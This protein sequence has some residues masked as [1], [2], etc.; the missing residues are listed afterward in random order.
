[1]STIA[2]MEHVE[3]SL[4]FSGDEQ[5][6]ML[7]YDNILA[8]Y[9]SSQILPT[10][11]KPN[12]P[13][14]HFA[15]IYINQNGEV[16]LEVSPSIAS[17]GKAIFT[18]DI[19]ERF[20]KTAAMGSRVAPHS[21]PQPI[22]QAK[23]TD[24]SLGFQPGTNWGQ[25]SLPG[26][27]ELIPCDWQF[28]QN[29]RQKRNTKRR[30][31]RADRR[32]SSSGLNEGSVSPSPAFRRTALKVSDEDRMKKYYEK[33]FDAFQQLNCRVIAKAYIKLVEPRKQ[34][35]HPYN[36]RKTAA[37][38]SSEQRADPEL[39]K[40]KWWPSGVTHKE[41]D[42]LL[43]AERIRLLIHILRELRESHGI[44]AEKLREAGMD[45]RR[46]IVPT[47]RLSILDEI[48]YVRQAEERYLNGEIDGDSVIYVSQVH[49]ADSGFEFD[50]EQETDG[51]SQ[52][53]ST[54]FSTAGAEKPN[55]LEEQT[56]RAA[57]NNAIPSMSSLRNGIQSAHEEQGLP[58]MHNMGQLKQSTHDFYVSMTSPYITSSRTSP[59]DSIL[60]YSRDC[61]S[62]VSAVI[63]PTRT[64][65][66]ACSPHGE[67]HET[68]P[69][70]MPDYFSQQ[71]LV[72]ASGRPAQPRIWHPSHNAQPV[73]HHS[74]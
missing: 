4:A 25:T 13:Y 59:S 22:E 66:G 31:S 42:H 57:Q 69:S 60:A 61:N 72:P 15:L 21:F 51:G 32:R 24:C 35:H 28:Q 9:H 52:T 56:S 19:K 43:K 23:I 63:S 27:A 46:Q 8:Q 2:G 50:Y 40:P 38:S 45:V 16:G 37:G 33:A 6:P 10:R 74:Y 55:I 39:T 44:T 26:P 14:Q 47:E 41:P 58:Y 18:P 49:L 7:T 62:N 67:V 1:M 5:Q 53:S 29:K 11:L 65:G 73:Y 64:P 17:C 3:K 54:T 36:G 70:C 71:L 34:V 20:L 30:D 68:D 12:V 48:Y